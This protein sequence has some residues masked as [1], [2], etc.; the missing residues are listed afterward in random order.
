[1]T[2][3]V[4]RHGR[5]TLPPS[6]APVPISV[7]SP[8]T[9]STPHTHAHAHTSSSYPCSRLCL[10]AGPLLFEHDWM[11][12]TALTLCDAQRVMRIHAQVQE[13]TQEQE[14]E[15]EQIQMYGHAHQHDRRTRHGHAAAPV[16]LDRA[17]STDMLLY[18]EPRGGQHVHA[19]QGRKD[20]ACHASGAW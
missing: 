13:Q 12:C 20:D 4:T 3:R 7:S 11:T 10:R 19:S 15:Q 14:Q 6:P 9:P 5:L 2:C 16:P 8:H 18:G 1:M 17:A